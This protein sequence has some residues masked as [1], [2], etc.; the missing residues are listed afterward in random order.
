MDA[1]RMKN[2]IYIFIDV[3]EIFHCE[4]IDAIHSFVIGAQRRGGDAGGSILLLAKN[5][6]MWAERVMNLQ[7]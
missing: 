1:D 7:K 2:D 5:R 3:G 4:R 6:A